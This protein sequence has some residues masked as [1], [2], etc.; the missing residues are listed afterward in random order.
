MM[1]VSSLQD[2]TRVIGRRARQKW[3]VRVVSFLA[4]KHDSSGKRKVQ[5]LKEIVFLSL[6]RSAESDWPAFFGC[7]DN[8]A[9]SGQKIGMIDL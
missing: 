5:P 8:D 2:R 3:K 1:G 9:C 4:R 6:R 7:T